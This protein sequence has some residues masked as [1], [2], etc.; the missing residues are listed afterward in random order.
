M[1][2]QCRRGILDRVAG[3]WTS[4]SRCCFSRNRPC[5]NMLLISCFLASFRRSA[6][7]SGILKVSKETWALSLNY[8]TCSTTHKASS[9]LQ[10]PF[11]AS[12]WINIVNLI[13]LQTT[14]KK[15]KKTLPL[16]HLPRS[17]NLQTLEQYRN[18]IALAMTDGF[19]V[20]VVCLLDP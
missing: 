11:I 8:S 9:L 12:L 5:R 16:P 10:K 13:Y 4:T 3:G 6:S 20:R 1:L 19:A 7:L 18:M 17:P 2:I 15:K 14:V